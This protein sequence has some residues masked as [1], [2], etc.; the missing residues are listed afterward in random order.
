MQ[1]AFDDMLTILLQEGYATEIEPCPE[2]GK[3]WIK[4]TVTEKI[5]HFEEI[6]YGVDLLETMQ[7]V[8]CQIPEAV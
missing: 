7:E 1:T 6:A 4:I 8:Y 3:D 5:G 2:K